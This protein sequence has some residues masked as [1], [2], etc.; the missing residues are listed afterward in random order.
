MNCGGTRA[1]ES[2]RFFLMTSR[3]P[4]GRPG[5]TVAWGNTQSSIGVGLNAGSPPRSESSSA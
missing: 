4:F 3:S 2:A 5:V 1:V